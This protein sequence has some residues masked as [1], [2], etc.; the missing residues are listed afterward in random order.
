MHNYIHNLE[1]LNDYVPDSLNVRKSTDQ[2]CNQSGLK[3]VEDCKNSGLRILNGRIGRDKDSGY[4]TYQSIPGRSV[5]DYALFEYNMIGIISDF[6]VQELFSISG[7]C[8]VQVSIKVHVQLTSTHE[9]IIS[10]ETL[11]WQQ[12]KS[13]LFRDLMQESLPLQENGENILQNNSSLDKEIDSFTN[14]LYR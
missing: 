14:T 8:P 5:I 1:G 12:D 9:E 11:I 2:T 3:L 7:H 10:S 4:Y 6:L 13:G